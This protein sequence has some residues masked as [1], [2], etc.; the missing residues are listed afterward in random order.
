[1]E[2]GY[3]PVYHL[4]FVAGVDEDTGVLGEYRGVGSG[5][6]GIALV[7]SRRREQLRLYSRGGFQRAAGGSPD[8]YHAPAVSLAAAYLLRGY[9]RDG[10]VL[11]MHFVVED[12]LLLDR[13]ERPEPDV[14]RDVGG[15]NA[16]VR[17]LAEHVLREVQTRRRSGCGAGLAAVYRVVAVLVLELLGDV[18]RKRHLTYPVEDIEEI[19]L[20][21]ESDKAVALVHDVEYLRGEPLREIHDSAWLQ[22]LSGVHQRFPLGEAQPLQQQEFHVRPRAAFRAVDTRREYLAV[23]HHQQVA[24]VQVVRDVVEV[25]VSYLAGGAVNC[26]QAGAVP[27]LHRSLCDELLRELVVE[28]GF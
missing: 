26:H 10:V 8:G 4:E 15:V 7:G 22:A 21:C 1:M 13:A 16:L 17:E 6:R 11:D 12:V 20:E 24:G 3:Q 5:Q 23:V 2:V 19:P 9:L 28:I 14:Q 25:A 18:G 27:G